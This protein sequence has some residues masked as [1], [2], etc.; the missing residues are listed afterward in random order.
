MYSDLRQTM[1]SVKDGIE[2]E[3]KLVLAYLFW[4][5]VFGMPAIS[6]NFT[7]WKQA[8]QTCLLRSRT[9]TGPES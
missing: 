6:L 8:R 4:S 5:A 3:Y 7:G 2:K 1:C 9:G